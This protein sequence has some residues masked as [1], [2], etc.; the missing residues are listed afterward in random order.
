MLSKKNYVNSAKSTMWSIW[1]E[2]NSRVFT[3]GRNIGGMGGVQISKVIP[4]VEF[5]GF[6]GWVKKKN[7]W[8]GNNLIDD[9]K[10]YKR[11]KPIQ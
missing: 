8:I 7:F 10:L 9:M 1:L 4:L 2:R 6:G 11:E 3:N 5:P